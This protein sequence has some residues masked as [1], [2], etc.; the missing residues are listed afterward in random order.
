LLEQMGAGQKVESTDDLEFA[1]GLGKVQLKPGR[2]LRTY[3][4]LWS[5][6]S[7]IELYFVPTEYL[8]QA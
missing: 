6:E 5:T 8:P 3:S 7:K 1:V 2:S 4:W